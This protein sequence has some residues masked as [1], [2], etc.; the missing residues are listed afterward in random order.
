MNLALEDTFRC[1]LIARL[2]QVGFELP[3]SL[4]GYSPIGP[5]IYR[6]AFPSQGYTAAIIQA[7]F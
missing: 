6:P 2:N 5:I 1:D 3:I 4:V 7:F